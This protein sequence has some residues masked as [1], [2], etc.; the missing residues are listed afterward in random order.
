MQV[1]KPDSLDGAREQMERCKFHE[2]LQAVVQMASA[3][4]EYVDSE[5]PWKQRKEDINAMNA[6]LYTLAEVVRCIGIM[7]QPFV[8]DSAKKLLDQLAVAEHARSFEHLKP[9][10]ALIPGTPLPKPEGI[11]PR[12]AS[13]S[14]AA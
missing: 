14:K 9:E 5:A 4:N 6:T 10:Y 7:L 13:D 1:T 11:F 8:P 2:I 12:V 3:A